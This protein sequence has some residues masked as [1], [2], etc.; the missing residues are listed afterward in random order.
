MQIHDPPCLPI[1]EEPAVT[2]FK[3]GSGDRNMFK[4]ETEKVLK[5]N[6][7]KIEI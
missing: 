1:K 5:Y 4:K 6:D 7:F 2:N 3:E